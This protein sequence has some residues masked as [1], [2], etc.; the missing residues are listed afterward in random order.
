MSKVIH[1]FLREP[2]HASSTISRVAN[3]S[4]PFKNTLTKL[5]DPKNNRTVWLIGTTNSST[6][7]AYRTKKLL[8]DVNFQSVYVQSSPLWWSYAKHLD[9][10]S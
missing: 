8:Q 1:R 6:T 3:R 10:L 5:E 9:V 4:D 7:L 2:N